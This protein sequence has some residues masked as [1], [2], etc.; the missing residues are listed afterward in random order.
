MIE[1]ESSGALWEDTQIPNLV[2]RVLFPGFGGGKR[3]GDEVDVTFRRPL[4][5]APPN[6]PR[7][8]TSEPVRRLTTSRSP[9]LCLFFSCSKNLYIRFLNLL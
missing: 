3:P 8:R 1:C 4:A 2:P 7:T 9:Y 5:S 6:L